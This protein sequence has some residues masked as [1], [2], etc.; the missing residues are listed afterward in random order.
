MSEDTNATWWDELSKR[1]RLL[2]VSDAHM[3]SSIAYM[4]WDEIGFHEQL[5][6]VGVAFLQEIVK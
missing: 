3:P 1:Q 5:D 6:L 2:I 4:A